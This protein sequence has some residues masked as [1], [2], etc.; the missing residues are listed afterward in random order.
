[1]KSDWGEYTSGDILDLN[2][3]SPA[4]FIDEIKMYYI[5]P[6]LPTSGTILEVGAGSGRLL[7]RIGLEH[8]DTYKVIGIDYSPSAVNIIR[9]NITKHG[10]NG[11]AFDCDIRNIQIKDNEVD[12]I[13]SGG[14][15]EHFTVG[16]AWSVLKEMYRV[17]KPG[18]IFYADIVPRKFSLCRPIIKEDIGGYETNISTKRW[19]ELLTEVGFTNIEI[20]SALVLPPN[21]YGKWAS[22]KRINFMYKHKKSF[23]ELDNTIIS[24]MLGF[25]YFVFAKKV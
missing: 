14:V 7:T 25:A 19:N 15:L 13:C 3:K 16:E 9:D 17:L 23:M 4:D 6:H 8:K 20:F 12:V 1:M 24:D 2:R 10:L 22:E 18:G 11:V 21:F 5:R